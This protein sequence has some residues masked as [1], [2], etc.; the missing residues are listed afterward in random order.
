MADIVDIGESALG[1]GAYVVL[2][3]WVG[4][5]EDERSWVPLATINNNA[6]AYLR[7]ELRRKRLNRTT[8]AALK[9]KYEISL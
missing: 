3:E 7:G 8:K 5:G 1:G 4:L 9:K 2:V 6:P